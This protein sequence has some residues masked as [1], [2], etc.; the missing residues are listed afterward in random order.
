M[1]MV[2]TEETGEVSGR[3]ER[4]M[5]SRGGAV[6]CPD[7]DDDDGC[8]ETR[9]RA[10]VVEEEW[11]ADEDTADIEEMDKTG[12]ER[13]TSS[14]AAT[15]S[16]AA[17]VVPS[18]CTGPVLDSFL[19]PALDVDDIAADS[20]VAWPG[21]A[22]IAVPFVAV[23]NCDAARLPPPK[24]GVLATGAAEKEALGAAAAAT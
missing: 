20:D 15:A 5:P 14:V 1:E 9:F 22:A 10:D 18:T 16:S 24:V 2:D 23:N 17:A 3:T 21:T 12:E 19:I 6:D 11:V 8:F 7:D 4:D 13:K